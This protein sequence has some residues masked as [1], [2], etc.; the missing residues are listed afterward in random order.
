MK[1]HTVPK[2]LLEQFAYYHPQ[3]QSKRLWRYHKG[4]K[5]HGNASPKTATRWDGHF[6]DPTNSEKEAEL[7]ERLKREFEDPV[8]QFLEMLAYKKF[9]WSAIHT[10]KLSGYVKML[11]NRSAARKAAS[12]QQV[13]LKLQP[14]KDLLED[15]EALSTLAAKYTLDMLE[16]GD[17]PGPM[18]TKQDV[19][20]GLKRAIKNN[21]GPDQSQIDYVAT[22]ETMMNQP[23]DQM[24]NGKWTI[25][26]TEPDNPFVIGDA[27][28]VTWE[29]TAE[30]RLMFGMGFARPNVEI[31]LPVSPTACLHIQP[32]VPRTREVRRPD[33]KSVV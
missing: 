30:N 6:A 25:I 24:I 31:M 18:V 12:P 13:A 5:P 16:R 1:S 33:R 17:L 22:I 23:D 11:F 28:V 10:I 15:E 19:L 21:S 14:F 8:N 32:D 7:E 2:K 4:W 26:P 20:D 3:T 27:P 29:R 9:V